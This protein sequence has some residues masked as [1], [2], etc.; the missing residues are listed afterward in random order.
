M[1][2]INYLIF[3]FELKKEK[4]SKVLSVLIIKYFIHQYINISQLLFFFC[5]LF[6][7]LQKDYFKITKSEPSVMC[8]EKTWNSIIFNSLNKE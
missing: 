8:V 1:Y 4:N 7:V 5:Y 6:N 3:R 2:I